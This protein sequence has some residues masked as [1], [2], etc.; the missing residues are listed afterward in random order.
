MKIP[1]TSQNYL[2]II[3]EKK[4]SMI[5][6][7]STAYLRKDLKKRSCPVYVDSFHQIFCI[8]SFIRQLSLKYNSSAIS[9]LWKPH[10]NLTTKQVQYLIKYLLPKLQIVNSYM[11]FIL[12]MPLI[13]HYIVF[14]WIKMQGFR[15]YN[16][17]GYCY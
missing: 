3:R 14:L 4:F 11:F 13:F 9:Y 8:P 5:Q 6:K 1:I 17:S 16:S 7:V 2:F 12:R 10:Y 15:S